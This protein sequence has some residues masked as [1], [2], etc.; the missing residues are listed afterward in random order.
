MNGDREL[1]A[2]PRLEQYEKQAKDLLKAFRSGDPDALRWVR[3]YHPRLPE[4]PDTN[5]R[6]NVTDSKVRK[7]KLTVNDAKF[8]LAR[9]HQFEN[10]PQFTKHI[11]ALNRKGS[12]VSQFEAAVDAIVTGN[13]T[14]RKRLLR[15]HPNLTRAR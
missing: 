13:I 1:P 5:D 9:Q 14:T 10:W 8:V 4:R 11:E 15:E 7:A 6:N 12:L 2:R 3:R